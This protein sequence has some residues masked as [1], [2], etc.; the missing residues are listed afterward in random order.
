[1]GADRTK[2]T[3][4]TLLGSAAAAGA[5]AAAAL[6]AVPAAAA[7]APRFRADQIAE[8]ESAN[9][10][11]QTGDAETV[12]Y[13]EASF[14]KAR[15]D[16]VVLGASDRITV[17]SP[18]G[19]ESYEYGPADV[20][21]GVLRALS[22]EGDTAEVELHDAADGVAATARLTAYS[23]GLNEDELASRPSDREIGPESVCGKD[24]SQNA[25]CYKETD[26]VAWDASRS[27]ARLIIED[28]YYCTAWIA[29]D[30]NRIMTNNHCLNTDEEA[31]ATE[32]QFGYECLECS[33]GETRT[34]LKVRGEE[35]LATN[36][37]Y[38]FTLFTVDD[39]EAIAHLPHLEI[40]PAHA[41]TGE[42]VFIPE[43]PGGRPL[44]IA[45]D[46]D[47]DGSWGNTSR[48]LVLDNRAYGRGYATDLAYYC[49]TEGGSSGSPVV[50][51]DTGEVVGLHHLGGCPNSAVRMDLVYPLIAPY[52]EMDFR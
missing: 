32:V 28:E 23:R 37:T 24:D 5:L 29:D 20:A 15:F 36:Y 41:E 31:R 42:K 18:D 3:I 45:A 16:G 50:S 48:C 34:P 6:T 14:I 22:I 43:H 4:N 21:G 7:E 38:D 27:V 8:L 33:G 17:A 19:A 10:R 12:A 49:D 35:V 39:Y 1:M 9:V 51:R 47:K 52:L 40:D 30:S 25:A 26:P 11:L 2:R 13:E 46:S 44:R